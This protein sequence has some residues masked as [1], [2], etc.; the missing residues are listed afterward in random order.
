MPA[1]VEEASVTDHIKPGAVGVDPR[2]ASG[3]KG[4][5]H[6]LDVG[7]DRRTGTGKTPIRI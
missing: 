5:L 2:L 1:R 4:G 6:D 7:I 3:G